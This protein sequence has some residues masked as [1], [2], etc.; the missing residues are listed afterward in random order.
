MH[1]LP[2]KQ[3][4]CLIV[5]GNIGAGKSTFL[6]ILRDSLNVQVVYEP[7][8]KWQNIGGTQNLLEMFYKDT[9]RWAYTF[10]SYA[11]V[12]RIIAQETH[13]KKC[14]NPAQILERSVY[15]DR[16]CF[17]K[18]AHELGTMNALEW[19][20][21][22]EWFSWL[23]DN[24][25]IKPDGFI[26]LR[27]NPQICYERLRKRNRSEETGVSLQYLQ[28]LHA[29]HEEWLIEKK[30]VASYL[31]NVPVLVLECDEE[32][33]GNKAEQERHLER[34]CSF[35]DVHWALGKQVAKTSCLSL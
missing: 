34:I 13:A 23:V 8:E 22:Q 7:H 10:Q 11:F 20:L 29:R 35:F 12:T 33:E 3:I 28:T 30:G 5:E 16:Y 24:Y 27:T 2:P 26:Y 32:F 6:N 25:T 17:A 4:K 18:T 31:Q 19:K 14:I 9:Q 15:S 1:S 21:Y